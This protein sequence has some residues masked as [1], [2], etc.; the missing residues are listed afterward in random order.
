MLPISQELLVGLEH[1]GHVL[2]RTLV[3]SW[4]SFELTVIV[5]IRVASLLHKLL[6]KMSMS[7]PP[8]TKQHTTETLLTKRQVKKNACFARLEIGTSEKCH[9][10]IQNVCKFVKRLHKFVAL[11]NGSGMLVVAACLAVV[12]STTTLMMRGLAHFSLSSE[13][14]ASIYNTNFSMLFC[15]CQ[16]ITH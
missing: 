13:Y 5:R 11:R 1:T 12:A 16:K 14:P 4:H 8:T 3:N 10:R 15:I 2:E 7:P 6:F 9:W